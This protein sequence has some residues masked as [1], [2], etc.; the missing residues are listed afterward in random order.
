MVGV[1]GRAVVGLCLIICIKG[2]RLSIVGHREE[3]RQKALYHEAHAHNGRSFAKVD[4][5]IS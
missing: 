5:R 2:H 1:C 3:G 4:R